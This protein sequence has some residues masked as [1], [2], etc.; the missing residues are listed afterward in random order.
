MKYSLALS[1]V[2]FGL[3]LAG[4]IERRQEEFD[5]VGY[6]QAVGAI[7]NASPVVIAEGPEHTTAYNQEKVA[8]VVVDEIAGASPADVTAGV[9]EVVKPTE[10][11]KRAVVCTSRTSNGPRVT[12][13]ADTPEAFTANAEFSTNAVN[14][15]KAANVPAGYAAVP[16]YVNL[17]ATPNNPHYLTY[18]S[19]R[20]SSYN[21][22]QCAQICNEMSGCVSFLICKFRNI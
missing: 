3:A 19:S 12:N 4:P 6:E 14:A 13:P 9:Q 17:K 1:T 21:P 7:D 2:A 5:I 11:A 22:G 16:G 8:A 10:V 18:V 15:A 20:L